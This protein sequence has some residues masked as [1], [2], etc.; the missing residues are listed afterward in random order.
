MNILHYT[1]H[2]NSSE[3]IQS[4]FRQLGHCVST[5]SFP[6]SDYDE[7]P[8]FESAITTAMRQSNADCIFTFDFFPL[9]SKAAQEFHIPY[10]SWIY[11][12]PHTTL[13]S[14]A[15]HNSVNYVFIFDYNLYH[16]L[17][18]QNPDSQIYH[19]P[20]AVNTRRMI[21]LLG[22]P[23][24]QSGTQYD[25]SFVGSLYERCLY[26]QIQ[27]LPDYLNGYLAGIMNAQQ[28]ICGGTFINDVLT[29]NILSELENYVKLE[30]PD[31]Y[32]ITYK[33]LFAD[34][35]AEKITSTERI[36]LLSKIAAQHSFTLFTASD[37]E[38]I[39]N[40]QLGGIVSYTQKMPEVFRTSKINLN[41][42]LRS[43]TSG[44]PLRAMDIMGAGGFL[45]SNY[46][47]ELDAYFKN[48]EDCILFENESDM[49]CSID[50]YLEHEK[51]R[52]EIACNGF[53]KVHQE[54]SYPVQVQKI[55]STVFS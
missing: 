9:I 54:F 39:P 50:Y 55:L 46:Q 7:D 48:G 1:W 6:F 19:L 8:L 51:E 42:T 23:P 24:E 26:N 14:P 38:L 41:I 33:N 18:Q 4:T 53:R 20:L 21:D 12:M 28:K 44:I 52:K 27:Y 5:I 43:I 49:L 32:Q 2:E 37:P 15:I 35:I 45:L 29:P 11:D 25:V 10:I 17:I 31:Q 16:I 36:Q 47:P 30:I 3:D 13:F 22:M 34:L 40:A